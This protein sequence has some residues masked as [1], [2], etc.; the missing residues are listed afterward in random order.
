MNASQPYK[1]N[2]DPLYDTSPGT[3][4]EYAPS[5]W[6]HHAGEPP[7][8]DGPVKA[9]M[10]VDVVLIGGGFTGLATALFLAR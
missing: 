2:Y 4:M 5:Y 9:D 8:D 1:P 7:E 10:D 6:R 3:A